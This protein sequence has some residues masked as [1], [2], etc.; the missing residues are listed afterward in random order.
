MA[1]AAAELQKALFALLAADATLTALLGGPA[2]IFDHVPAPAAFP[3]V[4]FGRTSLFDWS[5]ATERGAEHL[6]TL[7][8]WST[9]RGRSEALAILERLAAL[10]DD[11]ALTL[12]GHR[13]VALR[14]ESSE[15][16]YDADIAAHH[17]QL[18]LR[19]LTE[20]A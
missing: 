11:A 2:K 12:A 8:V 4:T 14:L 16:R 13:L 15:A 1:S 6:L 20:A 7:H 18:H 17:G 19:A 3:Y 10:L 5:T 9:G